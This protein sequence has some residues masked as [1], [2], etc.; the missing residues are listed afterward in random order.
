MR[1]AAIF[2]FAGLR[3][4]SDRNLLAADDGSTLV[5]TNLEGRLLAHLLLRPRTL[6]SRAELR[7]LLYGRDDAGGVRAPDAV[8]NRLRKKLSSLLRSSA[9][10]LIKTK[11]RC[12]YWLAAEVT[13]LP[14]RVYTQP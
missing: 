8:V 3:F 5:L 10:S 6:Y 11:V 14:Q 13:T 9:P 7:K 12:G 1:G 4:Q 2:S